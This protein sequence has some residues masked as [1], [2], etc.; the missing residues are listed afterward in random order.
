MSPEQRA[1]FK[2]IYPTMRQTKAQ[3]PLTPRQRELAEEVYIRAY[4]SRCP[5]QPPCGL[6]STCIRQ[7]AEEQRE[8]GY[9]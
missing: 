6:R 8:K 1:L 9:V 4:A 2:G 3:T 7:I 5:H